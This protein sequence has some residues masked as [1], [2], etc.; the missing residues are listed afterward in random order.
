MQLYKAIE[1]GKNCVF[2]LIYPLSYYFI[3]QEGA[4]SLSVLR[5]VWQTYW[6][7]QNWGWSDDALD[8]LE[9]SL[10]E[11]DNRFPDFLRKLEDVGWDL[12]NLSLKIPKEIS[13]Q[14]VEAM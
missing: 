1:I 6:L 11:L 5:S 8:Q 3:L 13:V 9:K 14:E 7:Y 2:A 10:T 12:N 4:R